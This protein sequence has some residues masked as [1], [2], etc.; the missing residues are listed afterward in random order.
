MCRATYMTLIRH[1]EGVRSWN[2]MEVRIVWVLVGNQVTVQVVVQVRLWDLVS[3]SNCIWYKFNDS[4][5][6]Y[7]PQ[8]ENKSEKDT[9]MIAK[10]C[11]GLHPSPRAR[12]ESELPPSNLPL[13][14]YSVYLAMSTRVCICDCLSQLHTSITKTGSFYPSLFCIVFMLDF[15]L[16]L[17]K[18]L[19]RVLIYMVSF[20][21]QISAILSNT[22]KF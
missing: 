9:Q 3:H 21:F 1:L 8:R 10:A 12:R 17:S 6:H 22:L 15:Y 7:K 4:V 11:L 16:H 13:L 18:S 2:L 5:R 20:L 19:Q 14:K